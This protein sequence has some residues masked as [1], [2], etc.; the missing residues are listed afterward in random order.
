MNNCI[1]Y[2]ANYMF[3]KRIRSKCWFKPFEN[4]LTVYNSK[5]S[6]VFFRVDFGP[7]KLR[8]LEIKLNGRIEHFMKFMFKK[9]WGQNVDFKLKYWQSRRGLWSGEFSLLIAKFLIPAR[10]QASSVKI[11]LPACKIICVARHIHQMTASP[12]YIRVRWF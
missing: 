1:E 9:K 5:N 2:I 4:A 8:F 10:A 12:C 7:L 11:F 3:L 6:N